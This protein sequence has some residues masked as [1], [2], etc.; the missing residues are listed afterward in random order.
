GAR[1][2]EFTR[3]F[4]I[5]GDSYAALRYG[6]VAA[7]ADTTLERASALWRLKRALELLPSPA[8]L[9]A[10]PAPAAAELPG[11]KKRLAVEPLAV[12]ALAQI[13]ERLGLDLADALA[14]DPDLACE[15]LERLDAEPVEAVQPSAP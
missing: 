2:P 14:R 13:L 11:S 12:E 1:G 7:H 10:A 6:P 9:R 5:I 3:T 8:R 4:G 15:L